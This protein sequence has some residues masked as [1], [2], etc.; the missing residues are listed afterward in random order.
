MSMGIRTAIVRLMK[1][2]KNAA[3]LMKQAQWMTRRAEQLLRDGGEDVSQKAIYRYIAENYLRV[4]ADWEEQES[5]E[6][7][8]E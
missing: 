6:T 5:G 1:L 3:A 8:A 2:D 7:A 4:L